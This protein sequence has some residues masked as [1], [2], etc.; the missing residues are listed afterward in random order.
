MIG[1]QLSIQQIN[2]LCTGVKLATELKSD[3]SKLR[4][5]LTIQGYSYSVDGK[6]IALGKVIKPNILDNI[7]RY[8]IVHGLNAKD[9]INTITIT[10]RYSE[11]QS[12][13][14]LSCGM[15]VMAAVRRLMT[16]RAE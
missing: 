7:Y 6:I 13:Q 10:R 14:L 15:S 1:L 8:N 3:N 16:I 11:C 4:K 9:M 2:N 12:L 5:F